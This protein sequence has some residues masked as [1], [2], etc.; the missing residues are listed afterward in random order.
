MTDAKEMEGED[1][2]VELRSGK[3]RLDHFSELYH[4][5]EE[6]RNLHQLENKLWKATDLIDTAIR[7]IQVLKAKRE[8]NFY[9]RMNG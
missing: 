7:D 2:W 9:E 4:N 3:M 1:K 5:D 8:E 6:W